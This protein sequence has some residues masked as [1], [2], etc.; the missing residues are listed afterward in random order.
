M[1]TRACPHV[2]VPPCHVCGPDSRKAPSSVVAREE[3]LVGGEAVHSSENTN[4]YYFLNL[5]VLL[6]SGAR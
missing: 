2:N 6:A 3:A 4:V 5:R 1:G